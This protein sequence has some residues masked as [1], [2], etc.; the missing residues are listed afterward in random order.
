MSGIVRFFFIRFDGIWAACPRNAAYRQ[1][2]Q[3]DHGPFSPTS[4]PNCCGRDHTNKTVKE[5]SELFPSKGCPAF[6]HDR[7]TKHKFVV[8]FLFFPF[9]RWDE[10][11]CSFLSLHVAYMKEK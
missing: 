6:N 7:S 4:Y 5:R 2:L 10:P 9:G 11:Q 8:F 1:Q 3:C